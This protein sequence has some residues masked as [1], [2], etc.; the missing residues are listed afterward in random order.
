MSSLSL[1]FHRVAW[2]VEFNNFANN[3]TNNSSQIEYRIKNKI[4][5]NQ[6]RTLGKLSLMGEE[7]QTKPWSFKRNRNNCV[8]YSG[9]RSRS[10]TR[11]KARFSKAHFSCFKTNPLTKKI[12]YVREQGRNRALFARRNGK[13]AN[14]IPTTWFLVHEYLFY[15]ISS[16][17]SLSV[18]HLHRFNMP[19]YYICM[20][21]HWP[22]PVLQLPHFCKHFCAKH[23]CIIKDD[24]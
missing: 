24:I 18:F 9:G 3:N 10:F 13:R 21:I 19:S 2:D 5:M 22:L 17:Q 14:T 12:N 15:P 6:T 7:G 11:P 23:Q 1:R 16:A 20:S 4:L 8:W